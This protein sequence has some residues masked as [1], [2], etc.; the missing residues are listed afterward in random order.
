MLIKGNAVILEVVS[1]TIDQDD[2][3]FSSY[4]QN[5]W[6]DTVIANFEFGTNSIYW[7]HDDAYVTIILISLNNCIEP[8]RLRRSDQ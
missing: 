6:P 2:K 4:Y 8:E 5:A 7:R 3:S 1:H